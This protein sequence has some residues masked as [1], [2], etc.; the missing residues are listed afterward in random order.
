MINQQYTESL[1][2]PRH[3]CFVPSGALTESETILLEQ[4]VM[5]KALGRKAELEAKYRVSC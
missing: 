5:E 4:K 3:L 2:L 1:R